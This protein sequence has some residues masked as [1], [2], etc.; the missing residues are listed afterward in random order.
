[1]TIWE[2]SSNH[3]KKIKDDRILLCIQWCKRPVW[4]ENYWKDSSFQRKVMQL[5]IVELVPFEAG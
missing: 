5:A 3:S 1:M 2:P 4:Y